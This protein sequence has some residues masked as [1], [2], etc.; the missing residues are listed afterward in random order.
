MGSGLVDS[1]VALLVNAR[2]ALINGH[3]VA[4]ASLCVTWPANT[5]GYFALVVQLE[6]PGR[7]LLLLFSRLFSFPPF[8]HGSS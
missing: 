4:D 7:F 6:L 8:Q 1:G 3:D 5:P 2:G